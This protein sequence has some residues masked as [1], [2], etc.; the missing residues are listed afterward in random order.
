MLALVTIFLATLLIAA[1]TIWL[2]R[3]LAGWQGFKHSVGV[4]G[5]Q[6]PTGSKAGLKLS[7]QQGFISLFGSSK[8]AVRNKRLRSPKNGIKAPW[9]W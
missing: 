9:G 8:E 5:V 7:A 4:P 1:A 6:R 3:S 2:Y